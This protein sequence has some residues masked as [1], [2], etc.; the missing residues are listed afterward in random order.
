[1]PA[2][3][4]A[5]LFL[6]L[7]L[8]VVGN[9]SHLPTFTS[10]G[11]LCGNFSRSV[12]DGNDA[13]WLSFAEAL[14]IEVFNKDWKGSFPWFLVAVGQRAE[15]PRVHT[16]LTSHL[17]LCVGQVKPPARVDPSLKLFGYSLFALSHC[18]IY[19]R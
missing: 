3:T 12:L 18:S 17:N 11:L 1:M 8:P 13:I 16:Q 19:L 9:F 4:N 15:L 7:L 14:P 6:L 10:L 5:T 2:G